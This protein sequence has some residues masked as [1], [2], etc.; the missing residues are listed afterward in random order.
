VWGRQTP[1]SVSLEQGY[2]PL[3]LAHGI[4]LTADVAEGQPLKWSD[5]AYDAGASAV[6]VRRDM[7]AI[8][9]RPNR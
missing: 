6:K 7:E 1:A 3:G 4:K 8:F 9:G 2:L 5:V